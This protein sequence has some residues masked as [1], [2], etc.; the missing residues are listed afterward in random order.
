[1]PEGR[2]STI[3]GGKAMQFFLGNY[4]DDK[5]ALIDPSSD[6]PYR[7]VDLAVRSVHF[8]LDP[9]RVKIAYV[10]TEDGKLHA[11]D[12]LSGDIVRSAQITEPYSKDGHWR[13]PRPRIAVMGDLIAVTD[14]REQLVRLID[15][16]SFEEARTINVEGLP[17]NVVAVGGS[18]LQH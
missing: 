12:V 2:V 14:P 17:F 1:M 4:G 18:G 15:A 5:L 13:D 11:L 8:Q 10:F 16:E 9:A 3:L 7:L 6:D